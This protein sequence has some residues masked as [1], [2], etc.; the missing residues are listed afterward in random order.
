MKN[1]YEQLIAEGYIYSRERSGYFVSA[2]DWPLSAAAAAPQKISQLP[3]RPTWF[4]DF[5]SGSPEP[6]DFPF[7]VWS[8]LMRQTILE[9]G[10]ACSSRRPIT[11]RRS[12]A[13]P[14]RRTCTS[15]AA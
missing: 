12:C 9:Q 15:S 14:S 4:L 3:P 6:D 2:M 10:R 1:A 7:T 5:A 8:R 13:A 11:A